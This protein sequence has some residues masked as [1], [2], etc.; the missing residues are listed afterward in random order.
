MKPHIAGVEAPPVGEASE[1][2]AHASLPGYQFLDLVR[3][4]PLGETWLVKGPN[5]KKRWAY[6]LHGCAESERD[7]RARLLG[8]LEAI[9]HAALPRVEAPFSDGSR[10]VLL[11]EP[12]EKSLRSR[13]QECRQGGRD[14]IPR[15]E[16][17]GYLRSA[18]QALDAL[19]AEHEICHLGLQPENILLDRNRVLLGEFGF[20]HLFWLPSG[21]PLRPLNPRYAA[22]ELMKPGHSSPESDQYSLAVLFAELM[23]G[24]HPIRI[25]NVK[26]GSVKPG[27]VA[28]GPELGQLS[29]PDRDVVSKAM[30]LRPDMRYRSSLEF[31]EALEKVGA[32]PRAPATDQPG[33]SEQK[34]SPELFGPLGIP[35]DNATVAAVVSE[36][37]TNAAGTT[38]IQAGPSFRYL[39]KPGDCLEHR[40][41]AHLLPGVADVKLNGFREEWRATLLKATV[42]TFLFFVGGGRSFWQSCTG[43]QVGLEVEIRLSR[44]SAAQ[45]KHTEVNVCIKPVGCGKKQADIM[46][47]EVGPTLLSSLR[48]Y[49]QALPEMRREERHACPHP[50]QIRPANSRG[51][52]E[53]IVCRGK[54]ISLGGIGLYLANEPRCERMMVQLVSAPGVESIEVPMRVVRTQRCANGWFEVGALFP[55]VP[56]RLG[57]RK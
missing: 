7:T 25:S 47:R 57:N 27:A 48:A 24:T 23:T 20:L 16:L 8:R 12:A 56:L 51:V 22:P 2:V 1:G 46:L 35:I 11:A 39:L 52:G 45:V 54:D 40:C 10:L 49:L 53:A 6:L 37:V 29:G 18:A 38:E 31:I 43:K 17:L 21:E 28:V 3:R 19:A 36:I 15:D 34:S 33:F 4:S 9:R 30:H 5:G 42:D 44:P 14:G 32:P 50:L 55:D 13:F 26:R 41:A